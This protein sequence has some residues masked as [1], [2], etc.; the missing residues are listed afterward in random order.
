MTLWLH[1]GLERSDVHNQLMSI[2]DV[3]KKVEQIIFDTCRHFT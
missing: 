2:T 3:H 1:R